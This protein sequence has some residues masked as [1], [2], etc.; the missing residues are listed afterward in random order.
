MGARANLVLVD[1]NGY[2]LFYSHWCAETIPSDIFWGPEWTL[3]FITRQEQVSKDKRG[4]LDDTWAEGGVLMDT[5]AQKL[6]FWG[7]EDFIFNIPLRHLYLE[8]AREVW[9]G[10]SVEWAKNQIF[11]LADY[12]GVD[13]NLVTSTHAFG[14]EWYRGSIF[15]FRPGP[16][17]AIASICWED[18]A[19]R[20]YEASWHPA[21]LSKGKGQ[22][23]EKAKNAKGLERLDLS[24]WQDEPF[25]WFGIH[26]DLNTHFLGIWSYQM[27][28][29]AKIQAT[30]Q[31]WN[32]EWWGDQYQE[33]LTRTGDKLVMP[34]RST[35][36]LLEKLESVLVTP[37]RQL[38]AHVA[39][40][41][42]TSLKTEGWV[43]QPNPYLLVDN[44]Q[45]T[46]E[47]VRRSIFRLAVASWQSKQER[48]LR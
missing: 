48:G 38:G 12:V 44:P 33:H 37:N 36:S 5:H 13:R 21:F 42:R 31:G 26:I 41:I 20:F 23:L 34:F 6:L 47:E 11:D 2:Q 15:E 25:L 22:I 28:P 32:V 10:W 35:E 3:D 45:T 1:Q 16:M 17:T 43:E 24:K 8:L 14:E 7:G 27:P 29:L 9:R 18:D 19:L 46:P 39:Q 4:W 40:K 30:W